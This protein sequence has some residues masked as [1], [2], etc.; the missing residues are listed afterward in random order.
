[1]FISLTIP[2]AS[3]VSVS[4]ILFE[5]IPYKNDWIIIF[6]CKYNGKILSKQIL[7][8]MLSYKEYLLNAIFI[9]T[10][11]TGHYIQ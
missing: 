7:Y 6:M 1:M 3:R 10:I 9:K 2:Q 4:F 8:C 5:E 11:V